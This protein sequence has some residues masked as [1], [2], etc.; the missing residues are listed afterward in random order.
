MPQR[1]T[2]VPRPQVPANQ[3]DHAPTEP[4]PPSTVAKQK[5]YPHSNSGWR[6]LLNGHP[7]AALA[8]YRKALKYNPQSASAY[9]GLGISLKNLGEIELAKKA[10]GKAVDLNPRLPS[11]LVHLGY[12]YA[13]GHYGTP[14]LSTARRL[15]K[16][17]A[18]LGDPF[19]AIAL[20]DLKSGST[21]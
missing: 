8:M 11:A 21:L 7:Q 10:L 17:A 12:L 9:L 16:E 13:E 20:L 14:D 1:K 6:L 4:R 3:A 18:Q 5:T 2:P 19:A 15:F